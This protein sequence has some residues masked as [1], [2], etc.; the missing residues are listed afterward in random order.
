MSEDDSNVLRNQ[1]DTAMKPRRSSRNTTEHS[2][3]HRR[4]VQV[5][6]YLFSR[7]VATGAHHLA[8]VRSTLPPF[9]SSARARVWLQIFQ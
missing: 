6:M 4:A 5:N 2:Q 7:V 3:S 1:A 9:A 8:S